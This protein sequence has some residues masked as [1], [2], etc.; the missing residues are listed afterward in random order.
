MGFSYPHYDAELLVL[1]VGLCLAVGLVAQVARRAPPWV[2]ILPA[3]V[4]IVLLLFGC[5]LCWFR[6]RR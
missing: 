5:V 6:I 4:L 2:D 3:A 1:A